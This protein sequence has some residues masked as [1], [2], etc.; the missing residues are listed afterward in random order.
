MLFLVQP[1]SSKLILPWFGGSAAVWITCMLF[2][3]AGLLLGYVYAHELI[4]R[5]TPKRQAALHSALLILS[6]AALPILP[7]PMW[8]P[9]PG[10]DPTWRVFGAL[11]TAVGAPYLLLSS[12]SPLL[13]SW[14]A[15][16][17][18]GTLPYRYFALS[19]AGSLI[20]LL[21]YPILFEPHLTSHQQAWIWS[22]GFA[23]FAALGIATAIVAHRRIV[24]RAEPKL[25]GRAVP[26]AAR[27]ILWL[28]LPAC[29]SALLLAVTNLLTQNIAPMPL[30]WV[31]P[32]STYLLTFVVCFESDRWYK[33]A[34]FL[35]LLFPALG[36]LAAAMGPLTNRAVAL[37]VPLFT[38]ALFVCSMACH[39]EL[40][41]LKPTAEQLT[42]FYLCLAAGGAIGGLFIAL[43]APH[44]FRAMYELPIALVSCPLLLLAV[45]WR[46]RSSWNKPDLGLSVWLAALAATIVLAGY[47]GRQIWSQERFAIRLARNFY[48]ALRVD[49]FEDHHQKVRELSHGTITHGIQFLSPT[50]RHMPT[51]Y[52][53][54]ESGAGLAWQ[55]LAESGSLRMGVV[56]LGA[57][58]L[59]A[60]GRGGDTLRFYEINPAVI[61]IA[62]TQF[63]YLAD[64]PAHL[65][66]VLGDARLSMAHEPG[67]RF[68]LLVIDAFSGDAIPIHLL[69][70]EA[71]RIYWRHLKP[72]GVLAV[73]VS[74]HYLNLAPV[75][76]LAAL[77]MHKE[78]WQVD[79]YDDEA[80]EAYTST[81]V[82]VSDRK[83]F[84]DNPLF[85]DQLT[86]IDVPRGLAMWTDDYSNLWQVLTIR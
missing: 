22:I 65:D 40:A 51:T 10:E 62:K 47:T 74:N 18:A 8:Q 75:V 31:V 52:Y 60:Y 35:P 32:L 15:G 16:M 49:E 72:D 26:R 5:L 73:H 64:C 54:W 9:H 19:N 27:L 29:A 59:A 69:T 4:S 53:A 38:A 21:S 70:R 36:C 48:G 13:Q 33:R 63:T 45:L 23:A 44:V 1:L 76:R 67:Q 58:T 30:L 84:F 82:L 57:G 7:T 80:R 81:Y 41:R 71:F 20:A 46:E 39:G 17:S 85:S 37:E 50:L 28:A 34:I 6:L 78:A 86:A 66:I 79:A 3:Q 11:A 55:T 43:I 14:Y 25:L 83:G 2:F 42:T 24:V 61:E 77:D 68:D 56:G 12:T